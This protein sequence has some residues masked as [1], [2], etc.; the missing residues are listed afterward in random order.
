MTEHKA[1]ILSISFNLFGV[2]RFGRAGTRKQ[3]GQEKLSLG[4]IL[5]ETCRKT[6]I[7]G[8]ISLLL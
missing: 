3:S 2:D 7:S 1:V 8:D 5:P 6:G 4:N